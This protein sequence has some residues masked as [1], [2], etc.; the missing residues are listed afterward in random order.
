ML[1]VTKT[2]LQ[3]LVLEAL[4][5]LG[6]SASP[7]EV[8]RFVWDHHE[9]DLRN[10]GDTFYSWQYDLRWAAHALRAEGLIR[11]VKASPRGHWELAT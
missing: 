6:G 4:K 9:K 5:G 3:G 10:S 11:P 8:S 1:S 2:G 7:V